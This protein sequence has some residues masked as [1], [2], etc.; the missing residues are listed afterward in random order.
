MFPRFTKLRLPPKPLVYFI[1]LLAFAL[2]I[3]QLNSQSFWADEA[4]SAYSASVPVPLF[5]TGLP[6]DQSAGY[7]F[8]LQNWIRVAG[9]VDF[10]IRYMSVFFGTLAVALLF[11][12]GQRL[13]SMRI[14]LIGAFLA[15]LNPFAVYYSQEARPYSV[16][17]AFGTAAIYWFVR[18]YA[19]PDTRRLWVAH[20]L[21]LAGTLY[22]HYYAFALPLT[23]GV[24]LIAE[25]GGRTRAV[26]TRWLASM[27]GVGILYLPWLPL[28]RVLIPRSWPGPID[29]I[30]FPEEVWA[31]F[32]AGATMPPEALPVLFFFAAVLLVIGINVTRTHWQGR[33][34][35]TLLILPFVAVLAFLTARGNGLF[36]KYLT[37]LLPAFIL[38]IAVGFEKLAGLKWPLTIVGL[39]LYSGLAIVSLQ[40]YFFDVHYSRP[41]WR[42]A[43]LWIANQEQ[44][45]D[46]ILFDGA[47]PT[48]EF[49]R[50]YHGPL[51]P[52]TVP[53]MRSDAPDERA[54]ARM[55]PLVPNASRVWLVLFLNTPGRAE[56]WLNSHGFQGDYEDFAGVYVLPYLFSVQLTP[57]HPPADITSQVD[58]NLINYR[59]G[60]ARAGDY[61]PLAL[62]WRKGEAG[63]DTALQA[64]VRLVDAKGNV[65]VALDR[66]PR[67]GFRPTF[68]WKPGE[69]VEDRYALLVPK[70]TVPGEYSLRALLY[71][72]SSG[73]PQL[74]ATL[75]PVVVGAAGSDK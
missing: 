17:L 56:E 10:S 16:V 46:V 52:H 69:S 62:T 21:T 35:T 18:A 70:Q 23:E 20:S 34:L 48:V 67:D 73:T 6:P 40:N 26:F 39:A 36:T 57:P 66:S 49:K 14:A 38:L 29:P 50:Y 4:I 30:T 68:T 19:Q 47:D 61:L 51:K 72:P 31:N 7:Y 60:M 43:A 33:F 24:W 42:D 11:V 5:F 27:V 8:L 54:T 22:T 71:D 32:L 63:V 41:N 13:F 9:D 12:L 59:V 65:I 58:I 3:Y 53:G 2:R 1:I 28:M 45:G 55:S 44:P 37:I 64:S 15:A 25:R 74:D 75:G